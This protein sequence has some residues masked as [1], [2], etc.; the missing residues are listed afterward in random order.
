MDE[1]DGVGHILLG[2]YQQFECA[3]CTGFRL[4]WSEETGAPDTIETVNEAMDLAANVVLPE[5]RV[6]LQDRRVFPGA[7]AVTGCRLLHLVWPPHLLCLEDRHV[8]ALVREQ[9]LLAEEGVVL[10]VKDDRQAEEHSC[11]GHLR[12]HTVVIRFPHGAVQRRESARDEKRHVAGLTLRELQG[13][14]G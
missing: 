11:R 5:I 13:C 2:V 9:H 6:Q 4:R 8:G 1:D 10:N 14:R 12:H 3:M 7:R